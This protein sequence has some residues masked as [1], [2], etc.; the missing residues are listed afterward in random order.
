VSILSIFVSN[1]V[2]VATRVSRGRIFLTSFNST[3]A[4]TMHTSQAARYHKP[5]VYGDTSLI[6]ESKTFWFCPSRLWGPDPST[7][8]YARW[9]KRRVFTQR[10][11]FC[12]KTR[13]FSYPL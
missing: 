8:I 9:L 4:K 12:S 10:C 13:Y 11:A 2:V 7:D 1:F 6:L 5:C 3:I